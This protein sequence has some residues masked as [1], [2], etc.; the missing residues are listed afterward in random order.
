LGDSFPETGAQGRIAQGFEL[1]P[2]GVAGAE[3]L[4]AHVGV[5]GRVDASAGGAHD[6]VEVGEE[7]RSG[8][9]VLGKSRASVA[10][11]SGKDNRPGEA[12]SPKRL[13]TARK[14]PLWAAAMASSMSP[15]AAPPADSG[16]THWYCWKPLGP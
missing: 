11:A 12:T 5:L 10:P 13:S 1:C 8:V 16:I 6:G 7:L 15:M 9:A 4:A 3:E 2:L 14:E